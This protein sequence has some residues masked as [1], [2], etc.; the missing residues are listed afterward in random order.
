MRGGAGYVA[1]IAAKALHNGG[2]KQGADAAA[3]YW[4]AVAWDGSLRLGA[5]Y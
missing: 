5:N 4:Q 2:G 1:E 3:R